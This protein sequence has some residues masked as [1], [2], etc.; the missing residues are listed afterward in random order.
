MKKNN[1]QDWK[2]VLKFIVITSA[3]AVL[4]LI[5]FYKVFNMSV[6]SDRDLITYHQGL[7]YLEKHDYENAYFNFSNVSK[8]S[9]LYEIALLRQALCA[10][11]LKDTD[12]AVKKYHFFIERF[13]DSMFIEKVYYALAQN[14]FRQGEYK[15]AEKTFNAIVKNYPESDYKTASNYYLGL[16]CKDKNPQRAKMYFLSYIKDAPDGRFAMNC[17]Q[18]LM[19]LKIQPEEQEN[20]LF[21][22]LNLQKDEE[23]QNQEKNIGEMKFSQYENKLIGRTFF[24]NGMYNDALEYLN[25][26]DLKTNWH[27]LYII[28]KNRKQNEKADEIFVKGFTNYSTNIED[29]ELY[30]TL[31]TFASAYTAGE[32]HG[33]YRELELAKENKAKGGDYILYK[34]S[35]LEDGSVK[36]IFYKEIFTDFPHSKF[37]PEAVANLFWN[38]YKNENY[39]EALKIGRVHI[40]N[41]PDS[42]SAPKVTY[43]TARIYEKLDNRNLAKT[44]YQ[45]VRSKYPDTYYAYRAH[46]KLGI[47]RSTEWAT[48]PYRRLPDEDVVIRFPIEYTNLTN[49]KSTLIDTILKTGDYELLNGI[50]DDNEILQSWLNYKRGKFATSGTLARDAI[51]KMAEKPSFSDSVYKLAYQL[52]Y[53]D[54]INKYGQQYNID[55]YLIAALIREESYYN[56]KA[57]SAAGAKGLMQLMPSTANYIAHK[58]GI[59]YNYLLNPEDNIKL[60]CA[61][62]NYLRDTHKH[63]DLFAIAAY[64]GGPNAVTNWKE[65][66][67][68]DNFDEFVENIPYSETRDYIKKVF[69]TYWI[70]TNI[71]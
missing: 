55:S 29:K 70:Y 61:Y 17:V 11:E 18:E 49:E 38:E 16:I 1:M 50:E 59:R 53:Q 35:Q 25:L 66:M 57:G 19:T 28:Y 27:Y 45:R 2:K 60:G 42:L 32:K 51:E 63:N 71:Y 26:A 3:F 36:N 58:A 15:K 44:Y 37:A 65:N 22:N 12:T 6:I 5:A 30:K 54:L 8:T 34:L 67:D 47:H 21:D 39:K 4:I 10:D 24:L 7:E 46:K 48:K 62:I 43:W 9:A 33:W 13:P 68:Y 56:A 31:D 40:N 23:T 64:N 14:Y 20:T 69:R 41:Y 52:H